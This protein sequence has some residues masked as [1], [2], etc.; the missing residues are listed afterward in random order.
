MILLPPT[1]VYR[2]YIFCFS[3]YCTGDIL[4][5]CHI[6]TRPSP[7]PFRIRFR[8]ADK[9]PN[10]NSCDGLLFV[11]VSKEWMANI[12]DNFELYYNPATLSSVTKVHGKPLTTPYL[13]VQML[14][15]GNT[16]YRCISFWMSG[17][18]NYHT[19][20]RNFVWSVSV[21]IIIVVGWFS[22]SPQ[23]PRC[24]RTDDD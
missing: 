24:R 14:D 21:T 19:N 6:P 3:N 11:P 15:D 13:T 16:F 20:I 12:C 9:R 23:R 17:H 5:F 7:I 22:Y 10:N 18:Q 2:C 4:C 1:L 8:F